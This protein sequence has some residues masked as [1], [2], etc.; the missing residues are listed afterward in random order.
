[1]LY[2]GFITMNDGTQN[3]TLFQKTEADVLRCAREQMKL[4]NHY[5]R[6]NGIDYGAG[7]KWFTYEEEHGGLKEL[8]IVEYTETNRKII[9]EL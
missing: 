4:T 3:R 6:K 5:Y 1:M 7:G 9:T 2:K 8:T